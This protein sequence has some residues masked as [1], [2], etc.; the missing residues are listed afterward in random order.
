MGNSNIL[1]IFFVSFSS[2]IPHAYTHSFFFLFFFWF[3][4]PFSCY[5]GWKAGE[6][7]ARVTVAS[8]LP[9]T[10]V[11][12]PTFFLSSKRE[13]MSFWDCYL[14]E[15]QVL[16]RHVEMKGKEKSGQATKD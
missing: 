16:V 15:K 2:Y 13:K 12:A 1:S 14:V 5:G 3:S 6:E 4:G 11:P 10:T 7:K 8:P 9:K